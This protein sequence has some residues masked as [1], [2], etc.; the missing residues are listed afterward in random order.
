MVIYLAAIHRENFSVYLNLLSNIIKRK[1]VY[2][3][4]KTFGKTDKIL[5]L[6]FRD[7][8]E[9]QGSIDSDNA[10]KPVSPDDDEA[11]TDLETDRLLGQQRLDDLD[12]GKVRY[13]GET[14]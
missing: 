2:K 4:R 5:W 14:S 10:A 11:D 9:S 12:D 3:P 1:A 8:N 6:N 13:F 7:L